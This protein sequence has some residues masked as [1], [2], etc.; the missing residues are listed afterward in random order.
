M[1]EPEDCPPAAVPFS[2]TNRCL[3]FIFK[4][5]PIPF[6]TGAEVRQLDGLTPGDGG[7]CSIL[8]KIKLLPG[9]GRATRDRAAP[10]CDT[11]QFSKK[12]SKKSNKSC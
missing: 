11:R 7:S 4:R 8:N 1:S 3:F 10:E 6:S 2:L 12:I 5:I 9:G